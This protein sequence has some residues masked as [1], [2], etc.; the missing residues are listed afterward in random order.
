[1]AKIGF[2][3]ERMLLGFGVD[4]VIDRIAEG[5]A[6]KGHAVT[7]YASLTDG[8]YNNRSY[9]VRQIPTA[10]ISVFP[11]YDRNARRWLEM[12]NKEEI[13]VWVISTFPFFSLIPMLD[14]PAVAIDYGICS[15]EGF[16][17]EAKLNFAYMKW[18][19]QKRYFPKAA[20]IIT[21]SRYIKSLLPQILQEKTQVIYIGADHYLRDWL[22]RGEP[23]TLV[24]EF[25]RENGVGE[26]DVL[27][28]YIGRLKPE[29]QPY[30]GTNDLMGIFSE[31][32]ATNPS[33]KTM[34]VGYG[35]ENDAQRIRG[36]G[37]R[38]FVKAPV[39]LM[40]VIYAATD[41]Y[42]TASRWEGFDLP[43][44]E[45]AFFG[46]PGVALRIGA[47]PEVVDEG[48]SAFL[49]DSIEGLKKAAEL[50]ASNDGLRRK[51]GDAGR[52]Y[53]KRFLWERVVDDYDKMVK[54]VLE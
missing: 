2:L 22:M 18:S 44:V 31:M 4:L 14:S 50:L 40:P 32:S 8:T 46:K 3:T 19:Q 16:S 42:V 24:K 1:M 21:I 52:A 9:A 41:V 6:A 36:L 10:A 11:L 48:N 26:N 20:R 49:A 5:L 53:S 43:L 12:L 45:A 29:G 30:K 54:E 28:T 39:E 7:V 47:H 27:L 15:T 25:R 38:P 51:M 33:V 17:R 35:D 23:A 13:E 37:I 34:M